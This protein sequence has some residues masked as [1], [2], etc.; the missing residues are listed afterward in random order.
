M[1]AELVCE[2][3]PQTRLEAQAEKPTA[4]IPIRVE[5]ETDSLRIRD[6]FVWNLNE[7]LITPEAFARTFCSDLDLQQETYADIVAN[8]IR[9]QVEEH[10]GVAS[11]YLGADADISEEE[12]ETQ[13]DEVGE[14]RVILSV[15]NTAFP[16]RHILTSGL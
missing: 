10:E 1:V 5:F 3:S 6:C 7:E 9:A 13:G 15:S 2:R 14:C 12:D 16:C 4:L 8:Q 11:M